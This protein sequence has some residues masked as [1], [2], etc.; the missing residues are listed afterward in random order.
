ME[1]PENFLKQVKIISLFMQIMEVD[2]QKDSIFRN[3]ETL[4]LQLVNALIDQIEGSLDLE[5]YIR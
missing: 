4:G 1:A 2:F 3:P 5:K